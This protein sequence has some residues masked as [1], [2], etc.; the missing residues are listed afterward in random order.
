[1]S[2][3]TVIGWLLA[4][5]YALLFPL[6]VIEGPIV[7]IIAGFLISLGQFNPFITYPLVVLGDVVGDL[8][9]YAQGRWGGKPAV[10]KWGRVFGIRQNTIERIENHFKKRPGKTLII[11]KISHF[12]GGPILIAAGMAQMPL[13]EFLWFNF[14]GTLPK[15]LLLLLLGFYFGRAYATFDKLFQYAGWAMGGIIVI[16]I[17]TYIIIAKTSK[18]YFEKEEKTEEGK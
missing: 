18:E 6:T 11:G 5:R 2:T 14:L 10:K 17:I 16:A 1:M 15:S 4:Y 9:M 12:F 8:F 7:T 3:A 13:S